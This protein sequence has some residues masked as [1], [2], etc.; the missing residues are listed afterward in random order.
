MY[1]DESGGLKDD[2]LLTCGWPKESL[3]GHVADL[4]RAY[5]FP[6]LND[7]LPVGFLGLACGCL[8]RTSARTVADLWIHQADLWLTWGECVSDLRIPGAGLRLVRASL[9][10]T[11]GFPGLAC[12]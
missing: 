4:E 11:S 6:W 9:W 1:V 10:L 3:A 12:A 8:T 7:G 2:V 5:G